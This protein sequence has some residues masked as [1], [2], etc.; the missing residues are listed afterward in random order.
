MTLTTR[1]HR[2]SGLSLLEVLT[3]LSIFL[4][5]LIALSQLTTTGTNRAR[6][7]LD[8]GQADQLCQSKLHE[9]A[10]GILPLTSQG[11]TPFDED[12][13]WFWSMDA[14]PS[15]ATNL[16]NVTVRV[17]W[18]R[19]NESRMV[20]S[21]S[22]LILD[23]AARGS[24]LD[25]VTIAGSDTAP[26]G[27]SGTSS[28]QG[29]SSGS[30]QQPSSPSGQGGGTSGSGAGRGGT[31]SGGPGSGGPSGGGAGFGGGGPGRGG[32]SGGGPS[33][34]GPAGGGPGGGGPGGGGASFGGGTGGGGA[35][36]G[37]GTGGGGA[38]FGGGTGGQGTGRQR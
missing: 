2:R 31:G 20:A 25:T 12:P 19:G 13:D 22:Q 16:W 23:P 33:G 9:V 15:I 24:T 11:E 35:S 34:G 6:Q 30:T 26:T 7:I 14:E 32:P 3:A 36:F 4:F 28:S 18:Q 8:L 5:S 10:S 38:S 1:H 29:T 37:G 21:L 17:G 27:Q